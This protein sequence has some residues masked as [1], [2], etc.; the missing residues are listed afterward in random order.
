MRIGFQFRAESHIQRVSWLKKIYD[1]RLEKE[2][3]KKHTH[4]QWLHVKVLRIHFFGSEVICCYDETSSSF[5][6][7]LYIF[8]L[9]IFPRKLNFSLIENFDVHILMSNKREIKIWTTRIFPGNTFEEL[10][11]FWRYQSNS[12]DGLFRRVL[13]K[14]LNWSQWNDW[15]DRTKRF[16][17]SW[18]RNVHFFSVQTSLNLIEMTT[19]CA[20]DETKYRVIVDTEQY[21]ST[22]YEL[23]NY[24]NSQRDVF[25]FS[26]SCSSADWVVW[27]RC[28]H[29]ILW[30]VSWFFFFFILIML[31]FE[32]DNN[33]DDDNDDYNDGCIRTGFE[34]IQSRHIIVWWLNY[35]SDALCTKRSTTTGDQSVENQKSKR[36]KHMFR[37]VAFFCFYFFYTLVSIATKSRN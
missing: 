16:E 24:T 31:T 35:F 9:Q 33:N 20:W 29:P 18:T 13:W 2:N 28:F 11:L 37:L 7:R 21:W 32:D 5:V 34:T 17:H 12:I 1:R 26:F 6:R 30:F 8:P 23:S 14:K 10:D 27:L 3:R 22:S 15:N 19:C 25:S 36:L 4:T